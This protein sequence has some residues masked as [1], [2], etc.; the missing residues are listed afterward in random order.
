MAD[1]AVEPE[2]EE[3]AIVELT[4]TQKSA[5]LMMLLGEDEAA[6]I[7]KN[8]SPRE[9]QHLGG[10][11]Y[12]VQGVEQN[13][14]NAVLDE[15][16][17]II[18]Q[19]TSLG[20]GAGNYIR[21]VLTK[22]LGGDKAQS[23]LSRI[24]PAS[25]E[26]PIEIL[27]WM[28]ARAISELILDEHPQIVALIISYL[29][30]G[31]AA[32]VLG[33]LPLELQPEVVRR[34]ATLETVQPDAVRELERVM[35]QKFQANTTLRASQIGGVKAAAK[36]MNFTKT[37]MEQRIMKDIKKENK[38]LMQSIQDNMFVFDSLV[39]SDERSLQTLLRAIDAE[40]LVL[41]LKGADEV[42]REKLFSCM[43]T[44]AAANVKDEM[45]ALGPVRLTE[46]QEAQKQI[47]AVARKMSDDG[48]I[49]LAGRGGDEMV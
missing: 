21:N 17:A 8:L 23:V 45:E 30:Y 34:I 31:L 20:L 12:S 32:D 13:T 39:I 7:L 48:T 1:P 25:S 27:D 40:L 6:E 33:L 37:A 49:V 9:V 18:K 28:D 22:A 4:G 44:R 14:V 47:I 38:D 24:T 36:I 11:M 16:L 46:V 43:S 42:L 2:G 10:A 3:D 19:Q 26:R 29:D 41:A 35:Q 5:I 15:F